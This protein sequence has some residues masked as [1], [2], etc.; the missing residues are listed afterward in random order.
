MST[1]PE[2]RGFAYYDHGQINTRQTVKAVQTVLFIGAALSAL[3]GILLLTSTT[4]F[5]QVVGVLF[6]L[7]FLIRGLIRL[8]SG[9]FGPGLSAGGRT[10]SIIFGVLLVAL[11]IF[12]MRNPDD[13]VAILGILIGISWLIDG[14]V[15]LLES[16]HSTSRGVSIFVGILSVVAGIVVLSVPAASMSVLAMIA[17]IFLLVIAVA[18]VIAAI[19]IGVSAKKMSA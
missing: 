1:S 4:G 10:L 17:G 9:I 11:G 15:T 14:I 16:S 13:S 7:Y 5:L 2:V 19:S 12:A 3:F 8:V 18:Q 6:G